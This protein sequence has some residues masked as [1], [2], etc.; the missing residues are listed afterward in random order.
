[1]KSYRLNHGD[2]LTISVNDMAWETIVFDKKDFVAIEE[3]T[4]KEIAAVLSRVNALSASE[5]DSGNLV[6]ETAA[7]GGHTALEIDA[8]NS[9]AAPALGLSALPSSATGAGLRAARL[10]SLNAEPFALIANSELALL[11]DDVRRK[12]VFDEEAFTKNKATANEVAKIINEKKKK[13]ADV[14]R[15]G[16][17][18]LV[19]NTT[20]AGSKLKIEPAAPGKTDAAEILGFVGTAAFDEPH[21]VEPARLVCAGPQQGI[22]V[23]NLTASPI[24]L[25]LPG[26]SALLP[27]RRSLRLADADAASSQLQYFIEKGIVRL[28]STTEE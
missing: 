7:A 3:A 12:V 18:M 16:R 27:G 11:V 25:H 8:A 19:S 6:L 28:A 2:T 4:A 13:V 24:E 1:M 21:P 23:V 26:G 14:T 5:D 17:V 20:G 10:V 15:D 9:T 22:E